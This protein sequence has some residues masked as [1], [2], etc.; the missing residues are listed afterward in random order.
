MALPSLR[1]FRDYEDTNALDN[2]AYESPLS[3][4]Y[5]YATGESGIGED[6]YFSN[7]KNYVMNVLGS[8]GMSNADKA[9][10][11][12]AAAEQ[13]GVSNEDIARA[14]G[15]GIGTV[16]TYLDPRSYAT[17]QDSTASSVTS[18]ASSVTAGDLGVTSGASNVTAP[19][20]SDDEITAL[21]QQV[22]G[23][24]PD[25]GGFDFWKNSGYTA[26]QIRDQF[27]LSD[28]Y[29]SKQGALPTTDLSAETS[30]ADAV[31]TGAL[32]QAASTLGQTTRSDTIRNYV[33]NVLSSEGTDAEKARNIADA[34]RNNNVSMEELAAATGFTVDQVNAYLANATVNPG[35]NADTANAVVAKNGYFA[36]NPDVAKAYQESGAAASMS[37]EEFAE[38]HWKESGRYEG[39][40]G[41]KGEAPND[42]D[43]MYDYRGQAY[44][45]DVIL[46]L[47]SQIIPNLGSMG[48]GAFGTKGES[49][50]F[51]FNEAKRI[52]GKDPSAAE[53]VILDMARSLVDK[54][55]T[56]I[57]QLQVKDV[58][59]DIEVKEL[60][61]ENG[62]PTG[63]YVATFVDP[64]NEYQYTQRILTKEEADRITSET[65]YDAEGG[66]QI[67]KTANDILSGKALY[68][69]NTLLN[70]VADTLSPLAIHLGGTATGKGS[71]EYQII[72]NPATGKPEFTSYGRDSSGL[73]ALSAVLTVASFIPGVQPFAMLANAAI[74]A[75]QG[76][77]LGALASLAGAG[78]FTNVATALNVA[79][80]VDKGNIGAVV[81]TLLANPT[82]A[83]AAGS[84]MLT[85]TI[86]L[87]DV[88]SAINI[89]A[90]VEK[91]DL[92]AVLTGAGKLTGSADLTTAG[93]AAEI[94]NAV[95]TGNIGAL[96]NSVMKLNGTINAAENLNNTETITTLVNNVTN[97]SITDSGAVDL[98]EATYVAAINAGATE[99]EALNAANAVTNTNAVTGNNNTTTTKT[100][101]VKTDIMSGVTA[102][103]TEF[104]NLDKA[105]SEATARNTLN[106][107]NAD[108]NS[109]EEAAALAGARGFTNFTY[110]GKTYAMSATAQEVAAQATAAN[111]AAAKN[112]GDA[113]SLARKELGPGQVFEWNGKKYSTDTR[114]ENPSL[115]KA[116]DQIRYAELGAG[117]GRGSYA[118]YDAKA[119]ADSW[120]KLNTKVL[121]NA[122]SLTDTIGTMDDFLKL[123]GLQGDYVVVG[124]GISKQLVDPVIKTIGTVVRA[125]GNF[126]DNM[127]GGLQSVNLIDK[128][129]GIVRIAN[130][131]QKWGSDRMGDYLIGA[132]KNVMDRVSKADGFANKFTELGKALWDNPSAILTLGA[133]EVFEE[134]GP[135][136][137][138]GMALRYGGKLLALG[139]DAFMNAWEAGGA[140]YNDTKKAAIDAG[141][142]ESD[143][144][145]AAQKSAAGAGA[146]ASVLGPVADM[147]W[148][149][150]AGS[151]GTGA[152]ESSTKA[153][154]KA[155][156]KEAATEY[157]EEGIAS[158]MSDYFAT[159]TIDL[160][161]AMTQ[162]TVG[163]VI[164]GKAVGTIT[165]VSE[166]ANA[167]N[168]TTEIVNSVAGTPDQ[169]AAL[170]N[171]INSSF[172]P[173]VDLKAAGADIVT[174]MTASGM[175]TA[176]A[177][178]V[179]N[180]AVAEQVLNNLS[181]TGGLNINNLN[182]AVGKD[183]SGNAVTLG[184]FIGSSV[185][186]AGIDGKVYVA[187]D[188]FIGTNAQGKPITVGDL[189]N[190]SSVANNATTTSS[191]SGSSTTVTGGGNTV[192]TSTDNNTG[193]TTNITTNADTGT[194]TNT[195]INNN[196]GVNSSTTTNAKTGTETTTTTDANT[197]TTTK[198]EANANTGTQTTTE[199]NSNT[200]TTTKTETNSNTGTQITTS[201]DSNTGTTTKTEVNANT[202]TETTTTTNSNTGTTT[203]TETNSNTGT[204][205][206]TTTDTNNNTN[207]SVTTNN[208][209]GATTETK[210][211]NN[212][213]TTTQTTTDTTTG[214][215][216][217][218]STNTNTNTN[219]STTTD[220]NTNT[221]TT[222]NTNTNTNVTTQT[223]VNNNT[224]TTTTSTTDTNGNVTSEVTTDTKNNTETTTTTDVN[225]NT[226]TTVV[227]DT[228]TN[229]VISST[230]TPVTE[231]KKIDPV[232]TVPPVEKVTPE[233]EVKPEEETE[234]EK[235]KKK[236][237]KL[238]TGA[239]TGMG[240]MGGEITGIKPQMLR[241][242]VTGE[243]KLDPL[244]RV[245]EIQ[246]EMEREAMIQNVDP[247]LAAI[248]QQRMGGGQQEDLSGLDT[249]AR[250]LSG[251]GFDP[252]KAA[253]DENSAYYSYGKEDS[254]DDILGA[255]A[256]VGFA[257][258]G[259]VEPLMAQGG[260]T[261]PLM[262]KEGGLPKMAKGREDFRDGKHVA[263]EGDGQSD[264]IPAM[265]ADGEFVF[266]AD[267]VSALGNGSTK[268]GTDKLYKMMHEIRAR[269]RSTGNKDL[270]PPA[271]KSPL[272]YLKSKR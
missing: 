68:A 208:N 39:R 192:S 161:K 191:A 153:V 120:A 180:T 152:A 162:G 31:V 89:A 131:M 132:E 126:L 245:K 13:Y 262:A 271:L 124:D 246:E 159:G 57:S 90:A 40:T 84:T 179:A 253:A 260:M 91:G 78:G 148:L 141:M 69:G 74:A 218:T 100:G 259:F 59:S 114:E 37:P 241:S 87:A 202:G 27:L 83:N 111:I 16:N 123:G 168:S 201:T 125:G 60:T 165:V 156:T 264:D 181:A 34:A 82:V 52:L 45:K 25:Q 188:I 113:Y 143:A 205:T 24:A 118:G 174:A 26:D 169:A 164:A 81:T 178:N 93:T 103:D 51:D 155:A 272:D 166:V 177:Q 261:L 55:I 62:Q 146:V 157:P 22:L 129:S 35:A 197:G 233:P 29:L 108:A 130:D 64:N 44:D 206:S 237:R 119:A 252:E 73:G 175:N 255:S 11:I 106:I 134:G 46:K 186:G 9:A 232:E 75:S 214:T 121:D 190:L 20:A 170:T 138:G 236:A 268:A 30:A 140:N 79:N 17:Q 76:N 95:Q 257:E 220:T 18:G 171:A 247:R 210:T 98:G 266:P 122:T 1:D 12:R 80:A 269:A 203:K 42:A 194:Q 258:G 112:F 240:L 189:S 209:T 183:S 243:K 221:Q 167:G 216:T 38:K 184:D 267:V 94:I 235:K 99:E 242:F 144:H 14:T 160:N 97:G 228:N 250:V 223:T 145:T 56:D 3:S 222:T 2:T 158:I 227:V 207:T 10:N 19:G 72:I 225:T 226:Q 215:T 36:A 107:A 47:A 173:G 43:K 248:L 128:N 105:I 127:A 66:A 231:I 21:Y 96:T 212:T 77:T 142:S 5:Q 195:S 88:G 265:L 151:V 85:D 213:G 200:G 256:P 185:T 172:K 116:S 187:P 133:N 48:G 33:V 199:T 58:F 147:P 198:T 251:G 193:A 136:A 71:T 101:D 23:R 176:Q 150:R 6:Q 63:Q 211:D 219:T 139:V 230:V 49:I 117:A 109:L 110:G 182:I 53:Q 263:G 7:I 92:A 54:G 8:E 217:T 28:E 204:S 239:G 115:A 249:L 137:A 270:P 135:L 41:P 229:T 102:V 67:R 224:G 244:E 15:Y 70:Q 163:S 196:T 61:D 238:T 149:K 50:G 65:I 234:E 154:T 4:G 254:I 104:G 86:S 32:D